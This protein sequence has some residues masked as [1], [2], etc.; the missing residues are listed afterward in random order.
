LSARSWARGWYWLS[1]GT[2]SLAL[3]LVL[4]QVARPWLPFDAHKLKTSEFSKF[5]SLLA[6]VAPLPEETFASNYQMASALS[7]RSGRMIAKLRGMNR[8]DFF[9]FSA[10]S[11]PKSDRF[12][13]VAEAGERLP[14][15]LGEQGYRVESARAVEN[16]FQVLEVARRAQDRG[17]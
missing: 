7:Y 3:L 15:W 17:R 5:D 11:Q 14:S 4:S 16:G 1:L 13:V 6:E 8:R 12:V 10:Q 9:D 2:W